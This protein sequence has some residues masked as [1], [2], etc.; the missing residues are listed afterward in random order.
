M[1]TKVPV[2]MNKRL[3]GSTITFLVKTMFPIE[4]KTTV[5]PFKA[6]E[7]IEGS[8]GA[9]DLGDGGDP[10]GVGGG[11]RRAGLGEKSRKY[12]STF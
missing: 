1:N 8:G 6:V 3:L 12:N 10:G 2:Q 11:Q 5:L 4:E 7:N 9:D